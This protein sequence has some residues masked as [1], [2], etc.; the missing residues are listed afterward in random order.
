MLFVLWNE[1]FCVISI[2]TPLRDLPQLI[3]SLII[4]NVNIANESI[5]R[6]KCCNTQRCK[7]C[8]KIPMNVYAIANVVTT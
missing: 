1:W 4:H 6:Y 7:R 2:V 8:G 5:C 3:L